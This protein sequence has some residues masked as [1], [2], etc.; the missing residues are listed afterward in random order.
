MLQMEIRRGINVLLIFLLI[1]IFSFVFIVPY[2]YFEDPDESENIT[3]NQLTTNNIFESNINSSLFNS[4][5]FGEAPQDLSGYSLSIRGDVNGDGYDDIL[6]GAPT[7]EKDIKNEGRVYLFFGES[8]ISLNINCSNADVIFCGEESYDAFGSSI[9]TGG[10]I[11]RDGYDDIL[12]GAPDYNSSRGKT[13]LFFGKASGWTK[14]INALNADISFFGEELGDKSGSS[15][16]SVGDINGDEF[17]DILIGAPSYNSSRGKT[18][19]FF[20]KASGWTTENNC[21]IADIFFNGE[22]TGDCYGISVCNAG[23]VNGDRYDDILIGAEK[24]NEGGSGSGQTYLFF[25]RSNGWSQEMNSYLANASFIGEPPI[26]GYDVSGRKIAY[27]GDINGDGY[28]DILIGAEG[29]DEG[30][31]GA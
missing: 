29:N 18:Y 1:L 26:T 13:Y 14:E 7:D 27:A 31:S 17:D 15:V 20:G 6:I 9:S 11:N 24:N 12:I 23:N 10:D 4:S 25:G 3:K 28:D 19:L 30:G 2:N 16:E 5:F 21:S 8:E 22:N